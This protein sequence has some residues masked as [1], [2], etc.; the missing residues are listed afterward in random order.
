MHISVVTSTFLLAL[1]V[2]AAPASHDEEPSS[3]EA[4]AKIRRIFPSL[5]VPIRASSPFQSLGTQYEAEVNYNP[6][7]PEKETRTLLTF[8]N[9]KPPNEPE[10]RRCSLSL[11]LPPVS[12][13]GVFPWTATGARKLYVYELE[14][15]SET[16]EPAEVSTASWNNRPARGDRIATIHLPN[17]VGGEARVT[18][19]NNKRGLDCENG[20]IDLE[21][22][23]DGQ[24]RTA[25]K[26]FELVRPRVGITYNV[27]HE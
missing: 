3:I 7:E 1:G 11:N 10:A 9:N 12:N 6:D 18:Y 15:V 14:N 27:H 16:G 17:R 2:I 13:P 23:G 5:I 22:A 24:Q 4:E 20:R 8:Y 19:E 21:I 26:W 25:F